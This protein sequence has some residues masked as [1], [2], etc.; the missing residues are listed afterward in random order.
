MITED[1]KIIQ[2]HEYCKSDKAPFITYADLESL[3]VKIYG[4]KNNP[5]KSSK[6]KLSE[7]EVPHCLQYYH[8]KTKNKHDVYRGKDCMV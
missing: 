8:L 5:V 1:N 2:F 3:I 4:C 7:H 6:T